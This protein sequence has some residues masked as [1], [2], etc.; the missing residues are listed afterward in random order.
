M[1]GPYRPRYRGFDAE[2]TKNAQATAE[3]SREGARSGE[4]VDRSYMEDGPR[5]AARRTGST[6]DE[7]G[8]GVDAAARRARRR[9]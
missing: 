7:V 8:T 4:H 3:R 9:R 1:D 5:E 2:G 6:A